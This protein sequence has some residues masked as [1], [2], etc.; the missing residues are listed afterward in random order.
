M[1]CVLH[2]PKSIIG[3]GIY[4]GYNSKVRRKKSKETRKKSKVQSAVQQLHS[5]LSQTLICV[6][7]A[8]ELHEFLI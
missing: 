3:E 5:Q 2:I 4:Y 7:K 6:S 8:L 1:K